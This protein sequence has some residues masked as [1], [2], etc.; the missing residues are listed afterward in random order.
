MKKLYFGILMVL[1]AAGPVLAGQ[2]AQ[3]TGCGLGTMLWENRAD[4]SVLS[5]TMQATTNGTSG[6]QTFGIT[7]GTLGCTQPENIAASERMIEFANANMDQL[8]RD[9]ATGQGE[10]LETLAELM[11]VPAEERAQLYANLQGQFSEIFVTGE[12]NSG[13]LLE[14]IVVAAN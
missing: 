4:N 2:A 10:S 11:N 3:N 13:V 5:Q 9:I 14:R 8:A 6:N 12:E 7:S 1:L